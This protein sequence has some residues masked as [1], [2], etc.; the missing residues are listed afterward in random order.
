MIDLPDLGAGERRIRAV[1]DRAVQRCAGALDEASR[2]AGPTKQQRF[3]MAMTILDHLAFS[4]IH[5]HA[6]DR[7]TA[8]VILEMHTANV[9]KMLS[10][11]Y[12]GKPV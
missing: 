7:E 1:A 10:D 9:G 6:I 3:G 4:A 2:E 5:A 8:K 12:G 11:R